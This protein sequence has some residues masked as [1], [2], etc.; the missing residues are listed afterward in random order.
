MKKWPR[1]R[2]DDLLCVTSEE[3]GAERDGVT[4]KQNV[5]RCFI[6]GRTGGYVS[7][8]INEPLEKFVKCDNEERCHAAI[9]VLPHF[10]AQS[11]RIAA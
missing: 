8:V 5:K 9:G 10:Y 7:H 2:G 3:A 1:V 6:V 11:L 4:L